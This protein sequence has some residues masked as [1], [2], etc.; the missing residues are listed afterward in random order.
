MNAGM[1]LDAQA[2]TPS[3]YLWLDHNTYG[4]SHSMSNAHCLIGSSLLSWCFFFVSSGVYASVQSDVSVHTISKHQIYQSSIKHQDDRLIHPPLLIHNLS[5]QIREHKI[6]PRQTTTV[7]ASHLKYLGR[8]RAWDREANVAF[9]QSVETRKAEKHKAGYHWYDYL[10]R[11]R[12]AHSS[13]R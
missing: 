3:E 11:E 10:G 4:P 13:Y 9:N 5:H 12:F 1:C 2:K 6:T 7:H 8:Y